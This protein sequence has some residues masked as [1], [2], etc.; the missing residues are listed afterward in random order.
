[1]F[2]PVGRNKFFWDHTIPSRS[3]CLASCLQNRE[4][5]HLLCLSQ[6][7]QQG[8]H[9]N[10]QGQCNQIGALVILRCLVKG[11]T[12][13]LCIGALRGNVLELENHMWCARICSVSHISIVAE[14]DNFNTSVLVTE[15]FVTVTV[16]PMLLLQNR[17][18]PHCTSY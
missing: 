13:S 11:D 18:Q 15:V 2:I 1:M 5:F 12:F 7:C 17:R 8:Q 6:S 10:L 14:T 4:W 3:Q 9:R 16:C